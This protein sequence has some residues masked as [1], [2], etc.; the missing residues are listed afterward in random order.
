MEYKVSSPDRVIDKATGTSKQ[1]VADYYARVLD[2][3]FPHIKDRPISLIRCPEG[4]DH[5]CFYQ[6]HPLKGK[7]EGLEVVDVREDKYLSIVEPIGVLTMVQYG[8]IEF[9]P[10]GASSSNVDLADR[11]IFDLDPDTDVTWQRTKDAA[12]LLRDLLA[13]MGFK[14]YLRLSGGKGV[15]LM[16][17]VKPEAPWDQVKAWAKA[18]VYKL[19]E[20]YPDDFVPVMIKKDRKDKIYVDYLRNDTASTAVTNYSLRA[21]PGL[22]VAVPI[23][24]EELDD[25]APDAFHIGDVVE[26]LKRGDPWKG[27]FDKPASL[28]N[29]IEKSR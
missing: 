28:K 8:A 18:L 25:F 26:L 23:E 24:W 27:F 10:W 1:D 11:L 19:A 4:I 9:H 6:R 16:C 22:P 29:V 21:R 13:N 7:L 3:M 20:D 2:L 17:N 5:P 12:R 15:H 14:P